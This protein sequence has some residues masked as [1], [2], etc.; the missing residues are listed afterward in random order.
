MELFLDLYGFVSVLLRLAEL[1]ARTLLLGS[2]VFWTLLALPLARVLAPGDA[3]GLSR[4]GRRWTRIA[5]V[6]AVLITGASLGLNLLAL[7][8]ATG[9]SFEA[10]R[11]A[12]FLRTGLASL[13][14]MLALAGLALGQPQLGPA[15][16]SALLASE[17]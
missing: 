12:D 6:A 8:A 1:L 14:V 5:A 3:A 17:P 11:G 4:I 10:L 13:G 16:R 9:L 7:E 2:V 15:R